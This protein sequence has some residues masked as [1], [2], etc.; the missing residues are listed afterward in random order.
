MNALLTRLYQS[1]ALFFWSVVIFIVVIALALS[2]VLPM[3]YAKT[4]E[5]KEPEVTVRPKNGFGKTLRV[6]GDADYRPFSYRLP[7]YAV[8]AD[9]ETQKTFKASGFTGIL[10]KP[11]TPDQ[12]KSVIR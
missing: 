5:W 7:V 8:T 9:V 11:V 1:T 12:L 6:V 3:Y 4:D 10:L 2:V